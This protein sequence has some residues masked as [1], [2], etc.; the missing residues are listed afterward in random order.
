MVSTVSNMIGSLYR[1]TSVVQIKENT[2]QAHTLQTSSVDSI[3]VCT[4]ASLTGYTSMLRHVF[5]GVSARS[6]GLLGYHSLMEPSFK[7][8]VL[9]VAGHSMA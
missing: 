4:C 7:L 9:P 6:T 3:Y 2:E 1:C 5:D 8:K